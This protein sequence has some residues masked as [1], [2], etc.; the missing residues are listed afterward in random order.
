[1]RDMYYDSL[2][3]TSENLRHLVAQYGADHIMIGSDYPYE[4]TDRPVDHILET[5]GLSDADKIAI[6]GGNAIEL[7]KL[8]V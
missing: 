6:L 1:M 5:P 7:F 2:V 4:W 8:D 3:F